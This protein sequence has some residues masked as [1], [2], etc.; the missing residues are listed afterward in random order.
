MGGGEITD[1]PK[2][3]NYRLLGCKAVQVDAERNVPKSFWQ[4]LL[5]GFEGKDT[6]G[7]DVDTITVSGRVLPNGE[8]QKSDMNTIN[9][10]TGDSVDD[11]S[12]GGNAV[13]KDGKYID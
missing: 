6:T 5:E 13:I 8:G 9:V 12:S 3:D 7:A 10:N 4:Q 1:T 11:Y 2:D